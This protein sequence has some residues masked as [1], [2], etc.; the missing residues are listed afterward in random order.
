M[1]RLLLIPRFLRSVS[2][3][4]YDNRKKAGVIA[5]IAVLAG[6]LVFSL[7]R[8]DALAK[9]KDMYEVQLSSMELNL[10]LYENLSSDSEA[11]AKAVSSLQAKVKA[12]EEE[13]QGLEG[14]NS[15]LS[16]DL[17]LL[18]E[19]GVD[20]LEEIQW[21]EEAEKRSQPDDVF[22]ITFYST[23]Y[24]SE[25]LIPGKTVAMNSQ[26]VAD[27][28]LKRGD[29][30]YIKS[31]K[32]WTGIYKITASGCAYGTIDIYV[33]PG[34]IPSYGVEYNVTIMI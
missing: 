19:Y 4:L 13:N 28:G 2:D 29:E 8:I 26:Q 24:V 22:K 9:E 14:I 12:L 16:E 7:I 5:V 15:E 21:V 6:A 34:D 32:G 31:N 11:L 20:L 25:F 27:L 3:Y 18:D 23:S 17:E 30:I 10:D 1:Y 33:A